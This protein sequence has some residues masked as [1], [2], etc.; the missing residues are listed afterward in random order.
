MAKMMVVIINSATAKTEY[1][2]SDVWAVDT[3]GHTSKGR[4]LQLTVW[5]GNPD[6]ETKRE[7]V[8]FDPL[9]Q[10]INVFPI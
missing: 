7:S 3:A 10:W 4:K 6:G 1:Q 9:K 8:W 5:I 2:A